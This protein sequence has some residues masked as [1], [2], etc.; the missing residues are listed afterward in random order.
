MSEDDGSAPNDSPGSDGGDDSTLGLSRRT[1]V[2]GAAG[3]GLGSVLGVGYAVLGGSNDG[4]Q[5][6]RTVEPEEPNED[7]TASLAELHYILENSGAENARL[8]V[9]EFVYQRDEAAVRVSYRTRADEVED[10]PP[11][12]QHVREVG[13]MV[14]MYAEYVAQSGDEADVVHAH[15]ENPSEPAEQPDGYLVRR[16]WVEKYN[17][18]EWDGNETLNTVFGS[19]YTDE[20]LEN[21]SASNST[22]ADPTNTSE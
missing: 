11:Q 21:E 4:D 14:R 12:R 13:Q 15:I 7:G 3:I 2:V 5:Q 16:E 6:T 17:S 18:G 1:I 8:D 19:S 22:T 9:T 10:V 20:A